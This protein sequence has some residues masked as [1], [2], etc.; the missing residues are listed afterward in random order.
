[1][2]AEKRKS[3]GGHAKGSAGKGSAGKGSAGKAGSKPRVRNNVSFALHQLAK[4]KPGGEEGRR[5]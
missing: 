2:A 1:M 4:V 5:D 3:S